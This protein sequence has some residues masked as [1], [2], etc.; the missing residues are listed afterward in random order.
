MPSYMGG[1]RPQSGWCWAIGNVK[2]T[3]LFGIPE[4]LLYLVVLT[5]EKK[6]AVDEMVATVF[7][8]K[9]LPKT[10]EC[11]DTICFRTDQLDKY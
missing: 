10:E 3:T 9:S 5:I 11:E 4:Q 1:G 2:V 7:L 6:N 8:K